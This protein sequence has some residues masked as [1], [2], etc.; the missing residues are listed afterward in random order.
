LHWATAGLLGSASSFFSKSKMKQGNFWM[1]TVARHFLNMKPVPSSA[2]PEREAPPRGPPQL[3]VLCISLDHACKGI[4]QRLQW[5]DP[6][7]FPASLLW[8]LLHHQYLL[9]C[10]NAF[11]ISMPTFALFQLH[12]AEVFQKQLAG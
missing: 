8:Q 7:L 9:A 3:V 12:A 11:H 2:S 1:S 5:N 4:A 10:R 6:M